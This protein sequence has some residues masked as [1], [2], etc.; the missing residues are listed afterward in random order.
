MP[1][2]DDDTTPMKAGSTLVQNKNGKLQ[3]LNSDSSSSLDSICDEKILIKPRLSET[4]ALIPVLERILFIRLSNNDRSAELDQCVSM[5]HAYRPPSISTSNY[6][7]RLHTYSFCS[8]TCLV[9]A[10]YLLERLAKKD[11]KYAITTLNVH[12]LLLVTLLISVK[13]LEDMSYDSLHFSNVGGIHVKEL[14]RL[15][16]ETLR[17]LDFNVNISLEDFNRF[18][19]SLLEE[20]LQHAMEFDQTEKSESCP[21]D[22]QRSSDSSMD[23]L[24]LVNSINQSGLL[25]HRNS[26]TASK[27]KHLISSSPISVSH[28]TKC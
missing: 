25:A 19:D 10:F 23:L 1:P 28:S 5:F 20:A 11:K 17:E 15:E 7:K 18:E 4:D 21:K 9:S 27:L 12:R 16:L 8:P 26:A 3:K 13:F 14:N 22:Q 24:K 6:L 2:R